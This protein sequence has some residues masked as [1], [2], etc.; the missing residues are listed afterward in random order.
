[1]Y[2]YILFTKRILTFWPA[3]ISSKNQA[4]K[5]HKDF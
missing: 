3:G 2:I 4:R 5:I 1:M